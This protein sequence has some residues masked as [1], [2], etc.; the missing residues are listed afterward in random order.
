WH[1]AAA[2]IAALAFQLGGVMAWRV[3]HFGQVLSLAYLPF[4]LLFLRRALDRSSAGYGAA[5]GLIAAFIALGRNQVGLLSLYLISGYVAW[6]WI[7][8]ASA[9]AAVRSSLRP[10]AVGALTGLLV[11]AVPIT[12]T[13]LLASQSNRPGI[14][15]IDAG[16]GSLH[17]ALLVTAAIPHLFGAAGRMEDYWGPPSFTWTGTDLFIAQNVGQLYLGAIPLLLLV[18]GASRGVLWGREIRFFTIAAVAMLLYALGWYTPA[19]RAAYVMVPGVDFYRRPADALFLVGGLGAVMAGY[20]AHR[21]LSGT[22]PRTG[23]WR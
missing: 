13:A 5:A 10:L 3:Q 17:P 6:H 22:L 4:A 16:R 7:M 11:A 12:L 19:F 9:G 23:P 2:L 14:D 8:A 21:L 20:V 18:I 15:F 1:W